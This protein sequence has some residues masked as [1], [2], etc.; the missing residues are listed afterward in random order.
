MELITKELHEAFKKQGDT[1]EK[2]AKDIPVI[3]KLFNPVGPGTWWVYEHVEGDVYMAYALLDEP[4]FA[5]LGTISIN[6]MQALKLPFGLGIERDIH[7]EVGS[8]TLQQVIDEV[9]GMI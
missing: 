9:E 2:Q 4:M 8:K 7:F 6:E 5:E 3:C 1:S